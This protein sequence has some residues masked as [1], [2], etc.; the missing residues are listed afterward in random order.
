MFLSI[1]DMTVKKN[2]WFQYFLQQLCPVIEKKSLSVVFYPYSLTHF[3]GLSIDNQPLGLWEAEKCNRIWSLSLVESAKASLRLNDLIW[4]ISRS[5]LRQIL[6]QGFVAFLQIL[7]VFFSN[8]W[9]S[10]FWEKIEIKGFSWP[11]LCHILFIVVSIPSSF[12]D[13]LQA[14]KTHFF[15]V[16][17][18]G[19]LQ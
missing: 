2:L 3:G 14:Y 8:H 10:I 19:L 13:K 12:H 5:L 16:N 15:T 1:L 11:L 17:L 7:S 4:K 6:C 18:K 9:P